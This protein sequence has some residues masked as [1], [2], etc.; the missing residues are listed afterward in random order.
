MNTV[1]VESARPPAIPP[2][3]TF[4]FPSPLEEKYKKRWIAIIATATALV[5]VAAALAAQVNTYSVT[6]STSPTKAGTKKKPVP[7]SLSF[8]YTVG[9]QSGQRP[10]PVKQYKIKFAGIKV[11]QT[12]LPTCTADKLNAAQTNTGCPSKSL[13]G[14]GVIKNEVG[15]AADPSVKG[16]C[17]LAL[18]IYNSTKAHL[19]LWIQG[20]CAGAAIHN[21]INSQ[22]RERDELDAAVHGADPAAAPGCGC[23]QRGH[24]RAVQDQQDLGRQ[25]QAQDGLLLVDRWSWKG[26]KRSVSVTFVSEAGQSSTASGGAKCTS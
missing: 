17:S 26:G 12:G 2:K 20:T 14:A 3:K 22:S 24:V 23:R 18:S 6:A 11:T 19:S 5:V 8:D 21:A 15:P 7:V 9:E 16:E 1:R 25:G 4:P 10:S 13:V